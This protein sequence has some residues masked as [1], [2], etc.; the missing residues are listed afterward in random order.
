[1]KRA[2][3]RKNDTEVIM[4][5]SQ[6]GSTRRDRISDNA[7]EGFDSDDKWDHFMMYLIFSKDSESK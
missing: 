1:M 6:R 7:M 3:P 4:N 2:V 5:E